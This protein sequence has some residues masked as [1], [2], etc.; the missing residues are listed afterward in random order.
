MIFIKFWS[1]FLVQRSTTVRVKAQTPKGEKVTLV[2]KGLPARI[3]QHEYDHLQ[4][5]L[6]FERMSPEVFATVRPQLIRYEEEYIAKNP[7]VEIQRIQ[8]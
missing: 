5:I 8:Q 6:F 2:L 4:Q 1:D 3:F 7:N